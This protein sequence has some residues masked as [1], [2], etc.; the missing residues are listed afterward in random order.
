MC[1][2]KCKLRMFNGLLDPG[3]MAS[4]FGTLLLTRAVDL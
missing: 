4:D 3:R 1:G 2:W